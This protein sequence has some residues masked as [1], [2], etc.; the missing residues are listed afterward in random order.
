VNQPS[1]AAVVRAIRLDDA[2]SET[3][4]R[5][6][7]WDIEADAMDGVFESLL[8]QTHLISQGNPPVEES[9]DHQRKNN[10]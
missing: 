2:Y 6:V 5:L 7:C 4:V 1:H 8:V 9:Q 3:R 10:G